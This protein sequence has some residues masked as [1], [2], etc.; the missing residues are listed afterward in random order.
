MLDL[1][2]S[3]GS[4]ANLRRLSVVAGCLGAAAVAVLAPF[5]YLWV[6][7]FGCVGLGLGLLNMALVRRSAVRY[8]AGTDPDKRRFAGSVLGR[9][10][11]ITALAMALAVLLRPAGLGVFAGLAAFQLLMIGSAAVPMI[12]S[13]RQAGARA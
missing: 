5:G 3:A 1:S 9:L 4:A 2:G 12:K 8:A 7:L 10:A 6:A 13:L 11:L